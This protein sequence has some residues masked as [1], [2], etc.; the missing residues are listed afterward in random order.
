MV[1]IVLAVIIVVELVVKGINRIRRAACREKAN[2][3]MLR[4]GDQ[5]GKTECKRKEGKGK[6]Y[7]QCI[8]SEI[9]AFLIEFRDQCQ[10]CKS[11]KH[12][13]R[14]TKKEVRGQHKFYFNYD[15][16]DTTYSCIQMVNTTG[17]GNEGKFK[18]FHLF[19][20]DPKIWF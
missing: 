8:A 9:D 14:K 18:Q 4:H 7:L 6:S 19:D 15:Y 1:L 2:Y 11:G 13:N 16:R 20:W 12:E 5:I 17:R 3:F 10:T